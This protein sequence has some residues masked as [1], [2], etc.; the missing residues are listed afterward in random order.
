MS[1]S[2]VLIDMDPFV[3]RFQPDQ[4]ESWRTGGDVRPHPDDGV[5][6]KIVWRQCQDLLARENIDL[7]QFNDQISLFAPRKVRKHAESQEEPEIEHIF[8]TEEEKEDKIRKCCQTVSYTHL[9]AHET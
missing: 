9:R 5:E 6:M 3:E 7:S 2:V 4:V 8:L 1:D